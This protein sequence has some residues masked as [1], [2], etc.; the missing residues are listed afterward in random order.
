MDYIMYIFQIHKSPVRET[1][2]IVSRVQD[3]VLGR[4]NYMPIHILRFFFQDKKLKA[5]SGSP[6]RGPSPPP[7][8]SP[9]PK[10]PPLDGSAQQTT[11]VLNAILPPKLVFG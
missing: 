11:E 1:S 9:K 6:T 8:P 4:V 2:A 10:L 7:C 3:P 5:T